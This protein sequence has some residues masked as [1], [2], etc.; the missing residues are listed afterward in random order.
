MISGTGVTGKREL[1]DS[2]AGD[3]TQVLCESSAVHPL[4]LSAV[5]PAGVHLFRTESLAEPKAR[6]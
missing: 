2:G 5:F 3:Q 6:Q 4:T 1:T